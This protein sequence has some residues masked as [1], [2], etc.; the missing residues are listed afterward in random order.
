MV[1]I[2]TVKELEQMCDKIRKIIFHNPETNTDYQQG[3][4]NILHCIAIPL[5]RALEGKL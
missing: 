5:A 3:Q 4:S 2:K 1:D